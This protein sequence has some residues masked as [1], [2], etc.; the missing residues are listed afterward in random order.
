[1]K[2]KKRSNKEIKDTRRLKL[3]DKLAEYDFRISEGA[4]PRI[5]LEALL[6]SFS[7]IE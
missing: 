1:M 2:K 6:A 4:N 7:V 5:Q 3:I